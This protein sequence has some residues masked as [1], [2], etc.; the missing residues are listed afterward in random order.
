MSL[1]R[2]VRLEECVSRS[3]NSVHSIS[4]TM[5]IV[6]SQSLQTSYIVFVKN[7]YVH[8]PLSVIFLLENGNGIGVALFSIARRCFYAI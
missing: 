5:Y 3:L 7:D 4:C 1:D 6:N 8:C 2:V